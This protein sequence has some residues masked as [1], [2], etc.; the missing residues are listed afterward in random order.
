MFWEA[1]RYVLRITY[2]IKS[3][4]ICD[5]EQYDMFWGARRAGAC[6]Y[7]RFLV[8]MEQQDILCGAIRYVIWSNKICYVGQ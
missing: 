7:M 3:N 6:S 5:M 8:D 2:F 4:K 1:I